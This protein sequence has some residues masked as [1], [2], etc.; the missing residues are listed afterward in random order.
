MRILTEKLA[1]CVSLLLAAGADINATFPEK[2]IDFTALLCVAGCE[3]CTAAI[4]VLLRAGADPCVPSSG[5]KTALHR[6]AVAGLPDT[7][8]ML[9]AAANAVLEAKDSNGQTALTHAADSG[10][11]DNVKRLLQCGADVN[12]GDN[13][14]TTPIIAASMQGHANVVLCLLK[15]GA[16]VN[17][18]ERA[19]RTTLMAAVQTDSRAWC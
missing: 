3:C 12:T 10:R 11:L 4:D 2:G 17:K 5:R 9:V 16:D 7:C 19:G 6:A 1:E 8:E 15:A 14:G 13:E 18:A